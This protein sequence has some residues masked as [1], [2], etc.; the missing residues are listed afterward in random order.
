MDYL[1]WNSFPNGISCGISVLKI[2]HPQKQRNKYVA[3]NH[4]IYGA[5][6]LISNLIWHTIQSPFPKLAPYISTEI[7]FCPL[8]KQIISSSFWA[9]STSNRKVRLVWQLII[10]QNVAFLG[11]LSNRADDDKNLPI[12]FCHGQNTL[13]PAVIKITIKCSFH[14][15]DWTSWSTSDMF[16]VQL[17]AFNKM[18]SKCDLNPRSLIHR[19]IY[20]FNYTQNSYKSLFVSENRCFPKF[21]ST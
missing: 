21:R 14:R 13:L 16:T 7:S 11:I 20:C 1:F 5:I 18:I 10:H 12:F 6:Q 3:N 15:V 19:L 4:T 9:F 17:D 8:W 2:R